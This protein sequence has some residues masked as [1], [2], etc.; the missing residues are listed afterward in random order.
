[1]KK[2]QIV[3]AFLAVFAFSAIAVTTASAE[4]TLLA[5]WLGNKE[6]FTGNLA[7]E[8]AGELLLDDTALGGSVTCSGIFTG[9]VT[10]GDGVGSIA[11]VLTL[12]KVEITLASPLLT[13]TAD[14]GSAC[15]AESDI[16]VAPDKLPWSTLIFLKEDGTFLQA[17]FGAEYVVICLSAL[18]GEV[19]D[20]CTALPAGAVAEVLNVTGG[21]EVMG[22]A[23]PLATCSL[24]GENA[25]LIEALPGNLTKDGT[26]TLE[27]SSTG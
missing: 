10:G 5:E 13:C 25:G 23:T 6:A 18:L 2:F 14:S 16:K 27:L 4:T 21:V 12:A 24:G 9:T 20:T 17:V 22:E 15:L 26:K 3:M 7:T 1:M 19:T 11:K 8:S